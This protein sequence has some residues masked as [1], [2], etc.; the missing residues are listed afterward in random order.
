MKLKLFGMKLFAGD[1]VNWPGPV[2]GS[3]QMISESIGKEQVAR[4]VEKLLPCVC[5]S[6]KLFNV[7]MYFGTKIESKWFEPTN[8]QISV[9]GTSK[10]DS[11]F[12]D[13]PN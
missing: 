4:C 2:L 3:N 6:S 7:V 12:N 11:I 9:T 10:F 8:M 1:A 5:H 13:Q